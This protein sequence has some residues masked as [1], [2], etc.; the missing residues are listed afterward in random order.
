MAETREK[1]KKKIKKDGEIGEK[2]EEKVAKATADEIKIEEIR[3]IKG[4]KGEQEEKQVPQKRERPRGKKYKEAAK[5][6]EKGKEY[7]VEEAIEL[8]KKTSTT[9]FD[10][11]VEAHFRLA[12]TE[13][14]SSVRGMV[15]LPAGIGKSKTV[16]VFCEEAKAKEAKNAGADFVGGEELIEKVSGGWLG[17]EIAIA[18]P[19]M[20]PKLAKV[21]KILGTKGL[22]PNPKSGTVTEEVGKTVDEIK[23]GKVEFRPDASGI[24]HQVIGKISFSKED[25]EA[26]FK[27]LI[28]AINKAKPGLLKN[29]FKSV[30][31][32]STMGPSV[33]VKIG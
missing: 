15:M 5:L 6:I 8:I 3:E 20:M 2:T 33:K 11:T 14:A 30:F 9:K 22:M 17:F 25:L 1:K 4:S 32:T 18:T 28:E 13:A 21:A 10:A 26:N 29:V 24:I 19:A 27:T 31:L 12:D 16:A 7:P 23:K